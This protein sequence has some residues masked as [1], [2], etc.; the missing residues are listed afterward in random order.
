MVNKQRT[1]IKRPDTNDP[2]TK[3]RKKF[4]NPRLFNQNIEFKN[5]PI[6]KAHRGSLVDNI[7]KQFRD[8]NPLTNETGSI[9]RVTTTDKS[10]GKTRHHSNQPMQADRIVSL[11]Q[12]K[13]TLMDCED[14]KRRINEL[15]MVSYQ[16]QHIHN[17]PGYQTIEMLQNQK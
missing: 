4:F 13:N 2:T 17:N 10:F 16:A 11:D 3:Q 14:T 7:S 8:Q 9:T 6:L 12:L 1:S 5:Q 15:A